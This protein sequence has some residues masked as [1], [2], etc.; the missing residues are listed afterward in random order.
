VSGISLNST[1]IAFGDV[2]L[3]SPATQTVTVTSTGILP[4]IVTAVT[5][6]GNG[7]SV[8]GLSLPL[9]L[10]TN[11]T[12]TLSV[13]FDPTT[14]GAATG[15]LLI[16][17]DSLANPTETVNMTGTGEA[18]ATSYEVNL[19]WDA[20]ASSSDPVAGYNVYRS[21]SGSSSYQLLG[22]VN[23]SKLSYTDTDSIQDGQTYD[24]IV[25]SVDASGN[26]SVPSNM[27]AVS[28]PN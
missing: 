26:E 20:P 21:P 16:V 17:S 22:S 24:Y 23:S 8:A 4:L 11:Q 7:F 1:S 5:I 2:S 10:T 13:V 28:I 15:Q 18:A 14:A 27:A 19:S 12:V 3:N 9:T 25:E 6:S